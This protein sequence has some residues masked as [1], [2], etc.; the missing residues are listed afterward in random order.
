VESASFDTA[1]FTVVVE[2]EAYLARVSLTT[3]PSVTKAIEWNRDRLRLLGGTPIAIPIV[4]C[5]FL[6]TPNEVAALVEGDA[7]MLGDAPRL[8]SLRGEVWLAAPDAE[9][10]VRAELV[11]K[12]SLVLRGERVELGWS[13]MIE[14]DENDALV[15]AVGD[16]PVV[17]RIEVGTVRMSARE[18]A[19]LVPG[20]VIEIARKIGDPVALRISGVEV[21]SGELVEVEGEIGVRVLSRFGAERAR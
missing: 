15:D 10:G 19:S 1:T 2:D 3:P 9:Y 14:P 8:R 17:V 7:W 12:G 18:W 5:V 11:D 21:A 13:P 16:I 20:D 4:A 6:T